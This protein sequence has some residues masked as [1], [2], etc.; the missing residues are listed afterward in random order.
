MQLLGEVFVFVFVF[1]VIEI[2][3]LF[4]PHQLPAIG[5]A[6]AVFLFLYSKLDRIEMALSEERRAQYQRFQERRR[7][8]LWVTVGLTVALCGAIY[9][10]HVYEF[11]APVPPPGESP[12]LAS[13]PRER[14]WE[15]VRPVEVKPIETPVPIHDP[16]VPSPDLPPPSETPDPVL[17]PEPPPGVPETDP[18][19]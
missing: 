7:E 4:A 10:L 2:T 13:P 5:F 12:R 1:V 14:R 16:V 3:A 15:T 17:P 11:I 9:I 19:R 18:P 8:V 6:L